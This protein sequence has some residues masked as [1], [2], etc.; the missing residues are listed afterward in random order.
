LK[1]MLFEA[2]IISTNQIQAL[3][4]RTNVTRTSATQTNAI[5]TKVKAPGIT[6]FP[7]SGR[8]CNGL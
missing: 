5:L 1:Q 7:E 3:V 6:I 4:H 2:N 8:G